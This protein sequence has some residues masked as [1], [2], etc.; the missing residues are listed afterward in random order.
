MN[1]WAKT[2]CRLLVALMIWMPYQIAT[3]GMIGSDQVTAT[4]PQVDRTTVLNFLSRSDVANKLHTLGID[5]S[6]AKDRVAAMS[7]QEV[8]S[9]AGRINAMP[10]GAMSD[11]A[12]AVLIIAIIA[13]VVW[14][15]WQR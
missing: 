9:L 10:A 4:S 3:A 11:T 12:E 1:V 2:I 13:A 6:N 14:W 7:D 15:F 5:P 8:Q